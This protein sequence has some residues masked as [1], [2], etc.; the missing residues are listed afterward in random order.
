MTDFDKLENRLEADNSH[1][2]QDGQLRFHK[3][4][5]PSAITS[6]GDEIA[7]QEAFN[8]F[9]KLQTTAEYYELPTRAHEIAAIDETV[10]GLG[11]IATESQGSAK[12]LQFPSVNS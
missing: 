5:S 10:A 12:V 11:R 3:E 6:E 9:A 4:L 7:S 1:E 8:A 2:Y